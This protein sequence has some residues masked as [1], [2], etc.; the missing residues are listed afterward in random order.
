MTPPPMHSSLFYHLTG[1][2]FADHSGLLTEPARFFSTRPTCWAAICKS[3][4][5]VVTSNGGERDSAALQ[6]VA[7]TAAFKY[8]WLEYEGNTFFSWGGA[9]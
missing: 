7:D 4:E 1:N 9:I 3:S 5:R 2:C 8:L 6:A